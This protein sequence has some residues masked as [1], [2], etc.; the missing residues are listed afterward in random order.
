MGIPAQTSQGQ[1]ILSVF[2]GEGGR[3]GGKE[4]EAW[5]GSGSERP[6]PVLLSSRSRGVEV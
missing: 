2:E 1:S 6:E 3:E 4:D 5:A